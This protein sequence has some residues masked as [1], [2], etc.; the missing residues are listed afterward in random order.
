MTFRTSSTGQQRQNLLD[1]QATQDRLALNQAQIASGKR[2]T[3]PGDDPVAAALILD[4]GT[5][6]DSNTQFLKQ[7]DSA[8]SFLQSASDAVGTTINDAT[9]LQELAQQG[10]SSTNA[11][12]ARTAMAAEVS[13]IRANLLALG[14]TQ[15]QGK[16]IFSGTN[17][18]VPAFTADPL[19]GAVTYAG[20]NGLINLN[21][22]AGAAPVATNVT[23]SQAFQGGGTNGSATD[24]FQVTSDLQAALTANDTAAIQVA[25]TRLQTI[26]DNLNQVQADLGGRQ[27]GLTNTQATLTSM[28]T[29]LQGL[30]SNQQDTNF[31]QAITQYSS[32]TTIQSATLSAMA[33]TNKTSLFDYL[34]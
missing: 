9:R 10:L 20:N 15:A 30:Q 24:I 3:Q 6:I 22:S 7:V 17:T 32:D 33:K 12:S 26:Q 1:L 16:Y 28:N 19:T 4:F 14:N 25:A 18:K 27:A 23:G 8:N 5:S 34:A 11:G 21:V 31:A 2:V 13:S 29:T